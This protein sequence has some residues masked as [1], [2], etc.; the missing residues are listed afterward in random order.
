MNCD[1]LRWFA[2]VL[3]TYECVASVPAGIG[4][5]H[6][7]ETTVSYLL[8]RVDCYEIRKVFVLWLRMPAGSRR[9]R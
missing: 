7:Y 8:L 1:R 3:L 2:C 5:R 4:L 9:L 6:H